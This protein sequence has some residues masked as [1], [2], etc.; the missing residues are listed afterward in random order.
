M[1]IDG[2]WKVIRGNLAYAA[3]MGV[4][5]IDSWSVNAYPR[6]PYRLDAN[7]PRRFR[8]RLSP[9]DGDF[10]AKTRV[11]FPP[12]AAQPSPAPTSGQ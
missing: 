4:G 12:R 7:Q 5:G 9:V 10:R 11:A 3:Q 8:Y 6:P 2:D 1:L